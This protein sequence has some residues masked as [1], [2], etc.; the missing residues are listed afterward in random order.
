MAVQGL[1]SPLPFKACQQN[2]FAPINFSAYLNSAGS[3]AM[4]PENEIES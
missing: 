2:Y 1:L 4:L 3:R